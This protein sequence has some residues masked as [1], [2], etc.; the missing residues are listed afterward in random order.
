MEC[1]ICHNTITVETAVKDQPKWCAYCYND[2]A[3]DCGYPLS[4]IAGVVPL[5]AEKRKPGS[6]QKKEIPAEIKRDW[7]W[8]AFIF[9]FWWYFYHKMWLKGVII[10]FFA[11]A[12]VIPISL[13][14][15]SIGWFLV[16]MA[17]SMFCK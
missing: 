17:E 7:N 4:P 12:V 13:V 9:G 2:W 3:K 10:M 5:V 16:L 1:K 15:P 6:E 14:L 11:A 8:Y